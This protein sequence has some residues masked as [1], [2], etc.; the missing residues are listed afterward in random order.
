MCFELTHS[1]GVGWNGGHDGWI[2]LH[3]VFKKVNHKQTS[4]FFHSPF[5]QYYHFSL[6]CPHLGPP[7]EQ[8]PRSCPSLS[9]MKQ[10][11]RTLPQPYNRGISGTCWLTLGSSAQTPDD[12]PV[13]GV[14]GNGS[15]FNLVLALGVDNAEASFSPEEFVDKHTSPLE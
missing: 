6:F 8:S 15:C 9:I 5:R 13:V 14:P 1:W 2:Q 10:H 3:L 12:F 4:S 11:I 7:Q